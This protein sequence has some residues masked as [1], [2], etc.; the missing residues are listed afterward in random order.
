MVA[1]ITVFEPGT[2]LSLRGVVD[3]SMTDIDFSVDPD[4]TR[5]RVH[6]YLRPNGV[7]AFLFWPNVIGWL[8]IYA[9]QCL[10]THRP[11][12]TQLTIDTKD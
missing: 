3:D 8:A 7:T 6:A 9:D 2:R 10:S 12:A 1:E 4:G 11:A 5:V